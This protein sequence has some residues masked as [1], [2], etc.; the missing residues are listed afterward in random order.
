MNRLNL[1]RLAQF[2]AALREAP[3]GSSSNIEIAGQSRRLYGFAKPPRWTEIDAFSAE[4]ERLGADQR[5]FRESSPAF[6][7]AGRAM[8][9]LLRLDRD[10]TAVGKDPTLSERG[11]HE[12]VRPFR[13]EAAH[14]LAQQAA[15]IR[16][17]RTAHDQRSTALYAPPALARDD[18]ASLLED[19]ELRDHWHNSTDQERLDIGALMAT[20]AHERI[21]LALLRGPIPLTEPHADLVR[22]GWRASVERREP[23]KAAQLTA[24]G[25]DVEWAEHVVGA[26]RQYMKPLIDGD[27]SIELYKGVREVPGGPELFGFAPNERDTFE[28]H[29]AAGG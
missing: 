18:L 28:R 29:I 20:G 16:T 15:A 21:A 11:R 3:T 17:H 14:S 2:G 24:E 23:A 10:V 27:R 22:R 9:A 5:E 19:R 26:A 4:T 7:H 1:R 13:V 12:K 8:T 6:V 25:A